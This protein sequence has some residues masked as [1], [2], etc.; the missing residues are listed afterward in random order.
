[1]SQTNVKDMGEIK[2]NHWSIILRET[3]DGIQNPAGGL[4]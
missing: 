2:A 4:A 1:M 3:E